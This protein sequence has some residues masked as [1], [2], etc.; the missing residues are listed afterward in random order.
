MMSKTPKRPPQDKLDLYD[1]LIDTHPDIERK[2][3]SMPYTSLNGH[4]YTYLSKTGSLGIRLPKEERERFLEKYNTT[5]YES[6]GAIMKEYVTVPD[7]LLRNTEEL[8]QYL[9]ISYEY[10]KTLKPKPS[11]KKS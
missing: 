6:H 10:V 4:M 2:G 9:D 1:R 11:K 7:E 5:L 8:K 3:V